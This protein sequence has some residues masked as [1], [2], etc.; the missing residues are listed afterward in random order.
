MECNKQEKP[1]INQGLHSIINAT[2]GNYIAGKEYTCTL[3]A[4][5][6]DPEHRASVTTTAQ[7]L[8]GK[9]VLVF[10]F[11]PEQTMQ[12]RKGNCILEIYD[13]VSLQEMAFDNEFADV[14]PNSVSSSK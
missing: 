7:E 6:G 9:V 3:Y 8:G 10:D 4:S 13:P 2:G 1:V 12:L 11:T 14:R 5:P